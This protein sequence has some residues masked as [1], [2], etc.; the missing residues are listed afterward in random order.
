VT[1]SYTPVA[2]QADSARLDLGT[3]CGDLVCKGAGAAVVP[4]QDVIGI[5]FNPTGTA[6]E[7][8][9]TSPD[10]DEVVT[11]YLILK[12]PSDSSGIYRWETCASI[13]QAGYPLT[14]SW[15]LS[16]GANNY[17]TAPCFNAQLPG[18]L[19]GT[20]SVV[21]ATLQVTPAVTGDDVSLYLAPLANPSLP[22]TVSYVTWGQPN[23]HIPLVVSSGS[24][25]L[26]VA[27]IHTYGSP[28]GVAAQAPA[29][30]RTAS[31]IALTWSAGESGADAAHVYRRVGSDPA[32]RLSA[33]PLP[34]N[35]GRVDYLDAAG[36]VARGSVLRYSLGLVRD[37][38]EFG[39]T[40]ETAI[41]LTAIVPATTALH[42][43]YP[44]PFNPETTI[45]FDLARAG[46]TRLEVFDASGRRIRTLADENL[47]AGSYTRAWDGRD[48]TGRPVP[49]GVYYCRLS[50]DGVTS[51]RKL[52]LLR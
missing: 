4:T 38:Q 22:G 37:D 45:A 10:G 50:T 31:G 26:P 14:A 42:P 32:A 27:R 34:V 3:H 52:M 16:G 1:V 6:T 28:L 30:A 48:A 18:P 41:T 39:R 20:P 2:A 49:S 23:S 29:V 33:L 5:Y 35:Q 13:L 19:T 8:Y 46:Q 17:A 9:V 25:S 15:S 7:Y 36:D 24:F 40:P 47:A 51:L 11:A 21:L 12:N 43:A 44:N